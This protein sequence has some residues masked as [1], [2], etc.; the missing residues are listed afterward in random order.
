MASTATQRTPA[1]PAGAP[2]ARDR[3]VAMLPRLAAFL[4]ARGRRV[5]VGTVICAVV[6]GVFGA[7]VSNSLWPYS[8]KDPAS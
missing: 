2:D 7:G 4:H 6:A 5:L 8:A 3:R 1:P